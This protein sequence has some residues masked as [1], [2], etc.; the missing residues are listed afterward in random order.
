MKSVRIYYIL[1]IV[2]VFSVMSVAAQNAFTAAE[3]A[4]IAE[5]ED[6]A[7]GYVKM[8]EKIDNALPKL[9]KKATKEQ[10]QAHQQSLLT[11]VQKARAGAKQG[12]IFIREVSVTIRQIIK[13]EFKGRDRADLRKRVF[14]VPHKTV[15]VAVNVQYPQSLEVMDMPPQLL[16][17]LPQLPK[18]LRFRLV[19][20]Y[21]LLVDRENEMIV[22]YMGNALP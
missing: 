12:E 19:G 6:R 7:K 1:A 11:G 22:D 9:P 10:I 8:R 4:R 2:L 5:F 21:L 13:D 17:A 20:E 3:K 15:K 14:E 16:L 18:Q